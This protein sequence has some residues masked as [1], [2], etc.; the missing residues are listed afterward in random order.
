MNAARM[1]ESRELHL[2]LTI[3]EANLVL[4]AVGNLPFHRVFGLVAK[5]QQQ[6]SQQLNPGGNEPAR[7]G[8]GR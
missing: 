8:D 5:I 4:E 6:A 1:H 3:D 2:S 7:M